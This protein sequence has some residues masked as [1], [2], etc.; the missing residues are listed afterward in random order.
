MKT[1][2]IL[3]SALTLGLTG[4]ASM[5]PPDS[6][7]LSSL[8]VVHFGQPV[9]E[10]GDY[11]LLFPAG[12]AIDTPVT[13]KG[14][15]FEQ[16]VREVVSVKPVKDIYVHKLWVSYDGKNWMDA[17]KSIDLDINVVLPG[18]NHPKPGFVLLEMNTKQ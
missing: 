15:L 11:V 3:L 2:T 9:P 8:P 7:K 16:T 5:S 12:V 17:A 18:Y 10:D 14:D 4:C 1:H 13:F 6:T